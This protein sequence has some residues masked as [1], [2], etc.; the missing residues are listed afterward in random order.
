ME[1]SC[2]HASRM[3]LLPHCEMLSGD[4][5]PPIGAVLGEDSVADHAVVVRVDAADGIGQLPACG[6]RP[7]HHPV[8]RGQVGYQ[9]ASL[10]TIAAMPWRT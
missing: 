8:F 4:S 10:S 5:I 1:I 2:G 6:L 3:I 9:L 7:G